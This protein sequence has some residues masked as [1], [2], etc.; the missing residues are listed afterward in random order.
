MAPVTDSVPG[1][2]LCHPR[3]LTSIACHAPHPPHPPTL[4][5]IPEGPHTT[6][7]NSPT[8]GFL[9]LATLALP[10]WAGEPRSL[11]DGKT[12]RGWE[13]DP[14]IW[15]VQDGA[16]TAG[17]VDQRAQRN[18][19]LASTRSYTNF[20]LRLQFKIEGTEGF[21]NSGV[22]I[23]SERIPNHHEMVGYQADI[24]EGWYGALYDESRRNTILAKPDPETVK[25]AVKPGQW[26]E[27]EIRADGNRVV[28]KI[29]GIQTVDYT[30]KDP[31][32][33]PHGKVAVQ[34]HGDGKTRVQFKDISLEELP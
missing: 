27:Y 6:A 9:A 10:M 5:S 8:A 17:R 26:N 18:E 31:K 33:V 3:P 24:G 34:I 14:K 22:Q 29:N 4:D 20:V 28:L 2:A 16:I 32:V 12:L 15:S 19:F 11:F 7:M 13:G 25:K 21:V 1:S 30:E 23:R